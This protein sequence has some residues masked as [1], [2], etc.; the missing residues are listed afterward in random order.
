MAAEDQIFGMN[1]K[2]LN[3]PSP[4]K[5][6]LVIGAYRD[7]D[8]KPKVFDIVSKIEKGMLE[9]KPALTKEYLQMEGEIDFRNFSKK[10]VFG[11]SCPILDNVR[12]PG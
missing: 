12:I 3:D 1:Q 11:D 6:S 5:I 4:A 2:Y 7:D 8:G 10:L 9:E